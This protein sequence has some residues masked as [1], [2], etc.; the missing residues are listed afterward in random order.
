VS[1]TFELRRLQIISLTPNE[2]QFGDED[3]NSKTSFRNHIT[4]LKQLFS[5]KIDFYLE[6]FEMGKPC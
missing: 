3:E 6:F 4:T 1:I 2:K 5:R